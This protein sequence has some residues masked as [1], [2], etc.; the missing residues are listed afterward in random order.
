MRVVGLSDFMSFGVDEQR[1][2]AVQID[3]SSSRL[4][5]DT[6]WVAEEPGVAAQLDA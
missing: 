5:R 4:E 6:K 3:L 2:E 1:R